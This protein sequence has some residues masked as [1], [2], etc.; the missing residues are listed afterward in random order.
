VKASE[1]S[2]GDVG[3]KANDSLRVDAGELRCRVVGEGGNLGFTQLGRIEYALAGGR[4]NTD[5]IDNVAGVNTSDHEVNIKI[6]LDALV[7]SG[8]MTEQQR[9]E[10]LVE[11]TDS[12]A[13]EV[14]VDN[15]T[16]TQAVSL[17]L[18]QAPQ[19]IDVHARLIRQLEQTAGL[20]R[21]LEF[22]PSEDTLAERKADHLGL[23]APE[24][25]VVMAYCKIRFYTQLL[26]SDVP[27]DDY[28]GHD[29]ERYFPEPLPE[30]YA[31]AMRSHRLRREII[32]TVVA[33]QVVERAGTSFVFRLTEETGASAPNLARAYAVAREVFTMH[34]FW[35]AVEA[36][37]NRVDA[38]TQLG[39][40]IEGRKLVERAS[41]WLI[42]STP[43]SIDIALTIRYFEPGA[44]MLRAAVPGVLEGA[45]LEAFQAGTTELQELDVPVELADWVAGMPPLLS[46]FDI[47]EVASATKR[48]QE[49][50][51]STY[52]RLG[53][54]LQLNWLRDR[55]LEL[56]R[57]NRWQ[58]L[59]RAALRDDLFNL[60]RALTREVL[61]SASRDS[62]AEAAIAA[63]SERHQPSLERALS[64]LSDIKAS[65]TYDTTTL[66]VAL[67]EVRNL[68]RSAE[69]PSGGPSSGPSTM[70]G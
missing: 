21:A 12:V 42:R 28:L 37:D 38:E 39:M 6:L 10:L 53:A 32:S 7:K 8:G 68:V 20:D 62:D 43:E 11:M 48:R 50:V 31:E 55:I 63:W 61:E 69:P 24:L 65:R 25:A 58:A 64:M 66:P 14:L 41:R 23:V 1:E 44:K 70:P 34:D 46:V 2:H 18:A 26:A 30:R 27:E 49:S 40:L 47:V 57:A 60:H 3:D 45:D 22:L 17:A 54:Q 67:R 35:S 15:Y 5:A 9:N 52:F 19:M 36:L 4:I 33:N 29:L 16:Q 13:D 51:M 59:A 56:P